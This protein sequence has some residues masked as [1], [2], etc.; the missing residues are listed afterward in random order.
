MA[1]VTLK[2]LV[3]S[4]T[5]IRRRSG[6]SDPKTKEFAATEPD[7]TFIL[8]L[9]QSRCAIESA[10]GFVHQAVAV[11][12]KVLFIGRKRVA[13]K[14]IAE[15]SRRAG[16]PYLSDRWPSGAPSPF[17]RYEKRS[18]RRVIGGLSGIAFPLAVVWLTS[19]GRRT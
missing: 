2:H 12:G 18:L 17:L 9:Q 11:G 8:D 10:D 7:G 16:M 14:R 5:P 15:Q 4:D 6:R 3:A 1:T 19:A 13:Q